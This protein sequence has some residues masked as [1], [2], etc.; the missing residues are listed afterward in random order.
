M[1]TQ[2]CLVII[3]LANFN[4]WSNVINTKIVNIILLKV[5]NIDVIKFQ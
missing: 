2:Q 5:V 3:T 4:M 1:S